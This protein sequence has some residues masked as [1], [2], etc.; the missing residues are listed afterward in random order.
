MAALSARG[1]TTYPTSYPSSE[2][3]LAAESLL[4]REI[5]DLDGRLIGE[6]H[7]VVFDNASGK[8]AY[9]FIALNQNKYADQRV[10]APWNAF[11]FDSS[12]RRLR[13]NTRLEPVNAVRT[14][15]PITAKSF[16]ND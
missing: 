2:Q 6:L 3:T 16:A 1:N 15:P 13:M 8:I 9:V 7:D 5:V 10:L 12:A 11:S 14:I 4:G